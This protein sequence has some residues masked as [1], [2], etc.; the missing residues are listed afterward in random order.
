MFRIKVTVASDNKQARRKASQLGQPAQTN[1]VG[2][3]LD[4]YICCQSRIILDCT[5]QNRDATHPHEL[6]REIDV[7][8]TPD[9]S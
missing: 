7:R 3:K 6:G 5:D 4:L 2:V 1:V 8:V 9:K